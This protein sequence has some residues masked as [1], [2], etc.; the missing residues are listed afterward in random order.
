MGCASDE[1]LIQYSEIFGKTF[2]G[3]GLHTGKLTNWLRLF[4]CNLSCSGFGQDNPTDETTWVLP[5][6]TVDISNIT[7]LEDLPVFTSGCDS[8]YSWSRRYEH[9]VHKDTAA[10]IAQKLTALNISDINPTGLWVHPLTL[11]DIHLCFTGGEPLMPRGQQAIVAV[12]KELI[13]SGNFPYHVT[14]ETNATQKLRH[15][16]IEAIREMHSQHEIEF[17]F[18]MSPKLFGVSGERPEKAWKP[19]VILSYGELASSVGHSYVKFV[20]NESS[21]DELT[22]RT[23]ELLSEYDVWEYNIGFWAMPVGATLEEQES[24]P[25]AMY[26]KLIE[27]GYNI[28]DRVHVRVYGNCIGK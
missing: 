10:T 1:K 9:L 4:N 17:T 2:Q 25:T 8:S 6:E 23:L 26:D 11:Q 12:M 18:S 27:L 3:E 22:Q 16:F 24:H 15:D 13:D 28:S 19:E 7:K 20:V 5:Y 21:F 14:F